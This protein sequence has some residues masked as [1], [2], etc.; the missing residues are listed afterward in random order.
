MSSHPY[1]MLQDA[2][3]AGA[4]AQDVPLPGESSH[5]RGMT[6]HRANLVTSVTRDAREMKPLQRY[7]QI[8][9]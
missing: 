3:I 7:E 9:L 6:R 2:A 5:A 1:I 8:P 4:G